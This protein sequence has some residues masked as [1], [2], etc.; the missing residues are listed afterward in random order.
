[1]GWLLW[2]LSIVWVAVAAPCFACEVS[3]SLR[4]KLFNEAQLRPAALDAAKAEAVWLLSSACVELSWTACPVPDR[5]HPVACDAG[6]GRMELHIL[7]SPLTKDPGED[8]LGLAMPALGHAVAF[9]SRVREAASASGLVDVCDLLGYVI[10]HELGH[11]LLRS[12]THSS[13]GVMRRGLGPGDLKK[14]A[15]R[16]LKFTSSQRVLIRQAVIENQ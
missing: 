5:R 10:A 3:Y 4:V 1:M 8:A 9:L 15:Q 11:L 2:E 6:A 14:A 13:E 16:Q 7:A 12:T